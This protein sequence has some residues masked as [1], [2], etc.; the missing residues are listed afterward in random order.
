MN[1]I[2]LR[3]I[4]LLSRV[5]MSLGVQIIYIHICIYVVTDYLMLQVFRRNIP[6]KNDLIVC[7]RVIIT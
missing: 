7:S 2:K 5:E 1:R 4:K 6:D 3:K